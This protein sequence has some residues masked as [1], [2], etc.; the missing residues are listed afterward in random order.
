MICVTSLLFP[1]FFVA[2][3][4]KKGLEIAFPTMT[5]PIKVL[6]VSL[7][8]IGSLKRI[9]G[10]SLFSMALGS[11]DHRITHQLRPINMN[12][13]SILSVMSALGFALAQDQGRTSP[14][15]DPCEVDQ[16]ECRPREAD[17][18]RKTNFKIEDF[19]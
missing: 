15:P 16:W 2:F 18:N 7:G 11:R 3:P 4:W 6:N 14:L 1:N 12:G 5:L 10:K 19:L 9:S 13:R 17:S 8:Q